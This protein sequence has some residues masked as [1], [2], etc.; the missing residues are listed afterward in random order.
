MSSN[1]YVHMKFESVL[2]AAI[3]KVHS[4]TCRRA[5]PCQRYL[6]E[7]RASRIE[8]LTRSPRFLYTKWSSKNDDSLNTAF[9]IER[10]RLTTKMG[11]RELPHPSLGPDQWRG[12]LYTLMYSD[13][14][15]GVFPPD[16]SALP[17]RQSKCMASR[18]IGKAHLV[19]GSLLVSPPESLRA[20]LYLTSGTIE[21]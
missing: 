7:N 11:I 13:T 15:K 10:R 1:T 19:D 8:V 16:K 4:R 6:H 17:I 20:W 12:W 2:S 18:R 3:H 21:M 9:S 14:S 5:C